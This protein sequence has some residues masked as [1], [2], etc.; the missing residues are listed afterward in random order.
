MNF[1]DK[2]YTNNSRRGKN[3][4][5]EYKPELVAKPIMKV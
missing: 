3:R 1:I 4:L 2:I 5:E